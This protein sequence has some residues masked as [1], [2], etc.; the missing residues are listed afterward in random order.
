MV[1]GLCVAAG[2]D[3]IFAGFDSCGFIVLSAHVLTFCRSCFF[4]L[5]AFYGIRQEV[6]LFTPY[7]L[8]LVLRLPVYGRGFYH[9]PRHG[10][11]LFCI[12]DMP[13]PIYDRAIYRLARFLKPFCNSWF[14]CTPCNRHR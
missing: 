5:Y 7:C 6:L 14:V 8:F 1:S 11:N 4:V 2:R 9:D 10:H 3:L 12:G 13:A